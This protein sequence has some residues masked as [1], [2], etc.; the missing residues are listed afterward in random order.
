MNVT[1]QDG[2]H[3]YQFRPRPAERADDV[4]F[5]AYIGLIVTLYKC[6]P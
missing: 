4:R 5:E 1:D 2:D 3:Y 6:L